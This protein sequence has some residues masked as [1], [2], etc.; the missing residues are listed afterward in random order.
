M[1][2]LEFLK[3]LLSYTHILVFVTLQLYA[4]RAVMFLEGGG[5]GGKR[6]YIVLLLVSSPVRACVGISP[7]CV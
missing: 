3:S 6:I 2:P 4:S 7:A 1:A 5:G